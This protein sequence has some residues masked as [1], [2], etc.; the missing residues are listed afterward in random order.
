MANTQLTH[1]VRNPKN[2]ENWLTIWNADVEDG[3][4]YTIIPSNN[5]KVP[6]SLINWTTEGSTTP[7]LP[8][9]V[10][11]S[12]DQVTGDNIIG[13]GTKGHIATFDGAN[14]VT[15]GPQIKS[16][17]GTTNLLNEQGQW[18]AIAT[19]D[20]LTLNSENNIIT[21]SHIVP[22]FSE[23]DNI[24]GSKAEENSKVDEETG[25]TIKIPYATYDDWGHITSQGTKTHKITGFITNTN[26]IV[27][28][29]K[30]EFGNIQNNKV[31]RTDNEGNLGWHEYKDTW[32]P[33]ERDQNGYVVAPTSE[34]QNKVW[35]TDAQGNPGWAD[36]ANT[37][38]KNTRTA[39]GYVSA[40]GTTRTAA[41]FWKV[42]ANS[43]ATSNPAWSTATATL[44]KSGA[45]GRY[46]NEIITLSTSLVSNV[47]I[48]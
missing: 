30:D 41:G 16:N 33:N 48:S 19:S 4:T 46:S 7:T 40:V 35:K 29:P 27:N 8:S 15:N 24:I 36:D 2:L 17:G 43:N 39:E 23:N 21:L 44:T 26:A 47:T 5:W 6:V 28:P 18:I 1:K 34:N 12:V 38:Q 3:T 32:I 14:S 11:V 20:K 9:N 31:W 37:W 45:A 13:S 10:T 22:D 42:A 25:I